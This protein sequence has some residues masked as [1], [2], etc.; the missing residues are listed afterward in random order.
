MKANNDPVNEGKW[1]LMLCGG[2]GSRMGSL[3]KDCPKALLLVNG[4]PIIWYSFWTLYQAGVRN[5]ILPIGYLGHMVKQYISEIS[6]DVNCNVYFVD[7]GSDSPIASRIKQVAHL[8]PENQNFFLINTDTIFNFDIE[9]M[10][11]LHIANSSL[12]TLSSVDIVS[13][14][15]VLTIVGDDVV[16]FDRD[17]KVQKLVSSHIAD[18]YGVINSGLAW[19]NKSALN[20][21]DFDNVIDFETDLFGLAIRKQK[22]SHFVLEG[23]WVPIDTPKDLATISYMLESS[24]GQIKNLYTSFQKLEA[25]VLKE[26]AEHV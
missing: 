4:R 24:D 14:W 21:I 17:R 16:G 25:L 11:E 19:I 13:P 6:K 20:F 5:F 26:D 9:S 2:L 15:G 7:T 8:I 18:G 10:Y 23:I 3:T 1:A 12:V 22:I